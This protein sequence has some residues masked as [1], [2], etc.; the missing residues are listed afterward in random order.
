MNLSR[1]NFMESICMDKNLQH[2][3]VFGKKRFV[4]EF[5]CFFFCLF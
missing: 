2:F 5:F 4:Y 3:K 1:K